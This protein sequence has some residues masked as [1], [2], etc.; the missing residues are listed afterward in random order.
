MTMKTA[1]MTAD[2]AEILLTEDQ[3]QERIGQLG[4]PDQR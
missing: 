3:L 1:D 4:A 2:V